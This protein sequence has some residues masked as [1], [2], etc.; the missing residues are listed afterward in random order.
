[1][2]GR[3]SL[4]VLVAGATLAFVA[5]AAWWVAA[6]PPTQVEPAGIAPQ[7]VA[8]EPAPPLEPERVDIDPDSYL[9]EFPNT[10]ERQILRVEPGAAYAVNV[11][12]VKGG[13][14]RFQYVC[15]G[16]GDLL[17]RIN[18]TTEGVKAYEVDCEGNLSTFQFVAAQSEVLVEMYR[19]GTEPAEVGIQVIAVE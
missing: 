2:E 17:V 19:P 4:A 5:G 14:Y 6:A 7:V 16:P 10:V 15:L 11:Q 3:L 8:P 1:M 9:P 12:A 18:G 13:E